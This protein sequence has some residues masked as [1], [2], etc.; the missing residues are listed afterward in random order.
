MRDQASTARPAAAPRARPI[1][2]HSRSEIR[3]SGAGCR[4]WRGLLRRGTATA[5]GPGQAPR[6]RAAPVPDRVCHHRGPAPAGCRSRDKFRPGARS[7]R[8]NRRCRRAAWQ[9]PAARARQSP[10]RGRRRSCGRGAGSARGAGGVRSDPA[11]GAASVRLRGARY[12]CRRSTTPRCR[13]GS[14]RDR[15][16]PTHRRS[17]P[18][19]SRA[20]ALNC[21]MLP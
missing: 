18:A 1:A 20:G 15:P 5:G 8:A 17:C 7:H 13:P 11:P 9:S 16:R 10:Y 3:H 6:W 21:P 14:G 2:S 12:R 4:H 19:S